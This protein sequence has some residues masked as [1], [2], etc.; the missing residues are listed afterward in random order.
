MSE[1]GDPI[2]GNIKDILESLGEDPERDGL[3]KTPHRA[4]SAMRMFTSGYQM[5]PIKILN[6]ALFDVGL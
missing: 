6:D 3:L 5:E 4:A 1:A 2:E